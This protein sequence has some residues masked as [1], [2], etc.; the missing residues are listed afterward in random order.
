MKT[1]KI[2]ALY[3][4]VAFYIFMGSMHFIKAEQ[5]YAMMPPWLPAHSLLIALSGC[6]EIA[7]GIA[8]IPKKTRA[9]AAKLIIAMLVIF[10]L[11]IHIPQ[12]IN[13][14]KTDHP[15]FTASMIRLPIQFLFMAWAWTFI[16]D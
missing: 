16:K 14:Y 12:S 2:I 10:L 5:Y 6:V 15:D 1:V 7:L 9:I 3:L 11:V 8:L 13:Y 4:L